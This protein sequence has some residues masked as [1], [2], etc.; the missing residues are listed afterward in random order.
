M[1]MILDALRKM[2][3]ERKAGDKGNLDIRPE[4]VCYS[5]RPQKQS[6]NRF[7]YFSATIVLLVAVMLA[8][9]MLTK[10]GP[11][12]ENG[13]TA[14]VPAAPP[15]PGVNTA[16]SPRPEQQV[17]LKAASGAPRVKA[18]APVASGEPAKA[19]RPMAI[20]LP[21]ESRDL[22]ISGIAWQDER[23][24]RRAV[25]NGELVSE[26]SEIA[27]GRIVEIRENR[28]RFSRHGRTFEVPYTSAFSR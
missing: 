2:E 19:P 17:T 15:E 6:G 3:Q 27:G 7:R 24:L 23:R 28:I 8:L 13:M 26:G 10:G 21:T 5:G 20:T 4:V 1:S 18:K 22:V 12:P 9:F 25:V 14:S 16:Q 11:A